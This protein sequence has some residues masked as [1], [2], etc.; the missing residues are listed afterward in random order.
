MEK[1][2]E[3]YLHYDA[4]GNITA[5]V[6]PDNGNSLKIPATTQPRE[7]DDLIHAFKADQLALAQAD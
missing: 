1:E 5:S 2:I 7:R 3:V 6:V 4:A